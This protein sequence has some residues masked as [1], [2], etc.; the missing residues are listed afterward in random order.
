[1]RHLIMLMGPPGSGKSTYAQRYP[2][3]ASTDA[4]RVADVHDAAGVT[5][6]Y[7]AAF[8]Y[9]VQSLKH[10]RTV[11]FD[12]ASSQLARRRAL[13]IAAGWRAPTTLVVF[14]TPLDVCIERQAGREY[15]VAES[16]VRQ[17]HA[18]IAAMDVDTEG[19]GRVQRVP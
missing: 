7:D 19:W 9:V 2:F 4:L 12:A 5:A 18:Q 1:M 8:D 6:V 15:P 17:L 14:D 3:V 11:V 10:D 16:V 13:R